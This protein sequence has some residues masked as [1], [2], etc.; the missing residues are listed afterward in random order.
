MVHLANP[1]SNYLRRSGKTQKEIAIDSGLSRSAINNYSHNTNVKPNEAVMVANSADDFELNMEIASQLFG[2]FKLM[3][4][5]KLNGNALTIDAYTEL[6]ERE[7]QQRYERDNIR[8][9]LRDG[10]LDKSE[11]AV[12]NEYALDDMDALIMRLTRFN[13][14]CLKLGVTP[15][16]LFKEKRQ[17]YEKKE[18]MEV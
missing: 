2:I 17:E 16:D 8:T 12:L 11:A 14:E 3:D 1:L 6:E 7:Q 13:A 9:L 18:Y 10:P 4:G 5:K 15:M